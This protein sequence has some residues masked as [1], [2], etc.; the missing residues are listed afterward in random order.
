[1]NKIKILDCTLRDGG[2]YNNWNFD[3]DIV[4]RYLQAM[5][6]CNVDIV[7]IGLRSDPKDNTKVNFEA[8]TEDFLS[9]FDM[10]KNISYAVMLNAKDFFSLKNE[11]E[12]SKAI[13]ARFLHQNDSKI[14]LVRVAVNYDDALKTQP[15]IKKLK[16]LNYMVGL[17]L[18]QSNGKSSDSYT[19]LTEAL[20]SWGLI[21]VLYFADS[22]GN[23]DTEDVKR[24]NT[25]ISSSWGGDIG[26][27]SHNNKGFALSNAIT[28]ITHGVKWCDCTVTGMG[29]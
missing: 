4:N 1:M 29:R 22:L 16:E 27:H 18:M 3:K 15:I 9:T 6:L 14:S 7:E 11:S 13:E 23:M 8:S 10:P 20:S 25:L 17:N 24:I 19:S 12:I 28:A 5:S 2:Y 26:F 21:D